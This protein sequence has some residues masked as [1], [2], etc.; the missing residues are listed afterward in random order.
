MHPVAL[1]LRTYLLHMSQKLLCLLHRPSTAA[2]ACCCIH[3]CCWKQASVFAAKLLG[4]QATGELPPYSGDPKD[5]VKLYTF[6][7]PRVGDTVFAA[8]LENNMNERYR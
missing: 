5:Q 2:A 8:Y 7:S 3:L 4:A 6:G 1:V